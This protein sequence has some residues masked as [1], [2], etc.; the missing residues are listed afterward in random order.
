VERQTELLV[1]TDPA[2]TEV[3][4]DYAYAKLDNLPGFGSVEVASAAAKRAAEAH[5][6]CDENWSGQPPWE[7]EREGNL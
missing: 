4:S 7:P 6:A 3:W 1:C 2:G 5:L